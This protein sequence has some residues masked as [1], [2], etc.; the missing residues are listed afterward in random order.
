MM[1]GIDER[2]HHRNMHKKLCILAQF[3]VHA[4]KV[5][6][7]SVTGREDFFIFLFEQSI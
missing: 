3:L 5:N 4:K 1:R 7:Y 6:L 2:R